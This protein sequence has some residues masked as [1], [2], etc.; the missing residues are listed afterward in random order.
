MGSRNVLGVGGSLYSGVLTRLVP[1][2]LL[3]DTIWGEK[4]QAVMVVRASIG[5]DQIFG[6]LHPL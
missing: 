1:L 5:N 4:H 2:L 3:F 6:P